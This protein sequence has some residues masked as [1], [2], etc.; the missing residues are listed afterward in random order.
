M[1]VVPERFVK[2]TVEREGENGRSWINNIPSLVES[3]CVKWGLA[4][5][6]A[7]MHGYFGLV[8]PVKWGDE[9]CVLKVSWQTRET[10][11]EAAALRAW[12]GQ[13]AVKLLA[14]EPEAG[15]M[16][17]ERLDFNRLL[18]DKPIAEAVV[19]AG[20]LLRR[21][22]ILV[23]GG[24]RQLS[25]VAPMIGDSLAE[26]WEANGRP[27]SQTVLER[28]QFY[29]TELSGQTAARLV[30]WDIHY[31]N[32]LAGE[33]EAWLVVD[34][35][36]VIGD[37]EYGLAQL[38]FTRLEDM[39]ADGGL[40]YHFQRLVEVA[41]VDDDLARAWTLVRVVD[42]WLWALSMGFTEDPV[43]CGVIVDWLVR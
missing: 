18:R 8:V 12:E 7:L 41:E 34:P 4:V 27:F 15:A 40:A 11:D 21:L 25:E 39:Q 1:I 14:H 38:L 23:A 9:A 17:L 20:Q 13:G 22:A 6:G 35:K 43:R 28:S 42:Y 24:F 33:R 31:E 37:P 29:A 26:R 5:D 36:V 3:L 2:D 30:N 10:Q 32:V 19:V 16:L